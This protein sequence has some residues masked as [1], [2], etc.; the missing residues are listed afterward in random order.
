MRRK[1]ST[2]GFT[3]LEV[4]VAMAIFALAGGALLE[5]FNSGLRNTR[6]AGEYVHA[7]AHARSKLAE[8][9]AGQGHTA[10]VES[11]RFGPVY[12]WRVTISEYRGNRPPSPQDLPLRPLSVV[13]EV[14]WGGDGERRSVRLRSLILEQSP[15]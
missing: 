6:L 9:N 10:G 1:T 7:V 8:I 14:F 13:V 15:Q 4:L 11:G 12:G 5:A 2:F 3:L